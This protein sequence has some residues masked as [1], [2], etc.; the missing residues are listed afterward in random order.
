MSFEDEF[1]GSGNRLRWSAIQ[2][3]TL[4]ND[5]KNRLGPFIDDMRRN[6]DVLVLPRVTEFDN[7]V[8]WYV[9]CSSPRCARAARDEVR[10]FLGSTYSDVDESWGSFNASDPVDAAVLSRYGTAAFKLCIPDHSLVNEARLRIRLM[11]DLRTERPVRFA[12][13]VRATGRALRDFE[14]ALIARDAAAARSCIEELRS[15]GRLGATN[16]LF[17]ETRVLAAL[18]QWSAIFAMP[19][20]ESLLAMSLPRRVTEALLRALYATRLKQLEIQQ[21]AAQALRVFRAELLPRYR[22]LLRTKSGLAGYEIDLAFLLANLTVDPPDRRRAEA[23]IADYDGDPRVGFLRALV[24]SV[25]EAEQASENSFQRALNAF[26]S[27][28]VDRAFELA[29]SLPSSFERLVL[30]FRCAQEMASLSAATAAISAFNEASEDDRQCIEKAA[31]LARIYS[32][33]SELQ[34]QAAPSAA[35]PPKPPSPLTSWLDWLS[36]LSEPTRWRVAVNVAEIGS[37]E[38]DFDAVASDA[39][40]VID[41]ADAL[42]VERPEWGRSALRDSLPFLVDSLLLRGPDARL[43]PVLENLFLSIALDDQ[44]SLPQFAALMRVA[45]ASVELGVA[46]SEYAEVL[47]Q[48]QRGLDL[49]ASPSAC[50]A[51]LET[52]DMLVGA[53]C[54]DEA[55]RQGFVAYTVSFFTRWY[56]RIDTSQWS[57]L[58]RLGEELGVPIEM[59]DGAR[60]EREA[61]SVWNTL[62]NKRVAL[63]SLRESALRR[64]E[65]V[66]QELC[67]SIHVQ[68]FAD[69]VGGSPALRTAAATADVF[70]VAA[71]AAKHAATI[72]IDANRPKDR[73]TLYARG[74]GSASLLEALR[75]HL[76]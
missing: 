64:I 69:H 49:I 40:A 65:L 15:T 1:F 27:G 6:P 58:L 70:V 39:S 30:L 21:D 74:Q 20:F 34:P 71:A 73:A 44:M 24:S 52:V 9:L 76:E 75:A 14:Y 19:E 4:S 22:G 26:A 62:N 51:A 56:R 10:A 25:P 43:K 3:G 50:S 61:G 32:H 54:P 11:M 17:M 72:F 41:L 67:P 31:G 5:A 12:R 46:P 45:E 36:R 55:A 13:Q 53:P 29:L 8:E 60:L 35:A 57:L 37:R 42:L 63:Y 59:P 66:L 68:T 28:Q 18:E 47:A 48:L 16:A 23:I 33:L 2:N 38:W 7:R